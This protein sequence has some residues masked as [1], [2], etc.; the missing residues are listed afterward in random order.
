MRLPVDDR[1][2]SD[3]AFPGLSIDGSQGGATEHPF[4]TIEMPQ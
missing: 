3:M 1:Y 2:S 4:E